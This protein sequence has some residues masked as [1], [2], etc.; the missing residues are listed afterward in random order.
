MYKKILDFT[1]DF[2]PKII[3]LPKEVENLK[4]EKFGDKEVLTGIEV[5]LNGKK[6]TLRM[7]DTLSVDEVGNYLW[8]SYD[9]GSNHYKKD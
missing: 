6:A 8:T 9:F 3:E 5:E 7:L 2:N 1:K 4:Y